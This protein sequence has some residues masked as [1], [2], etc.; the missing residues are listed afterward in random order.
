MSKCRKNKEPVHTNTKK[1]TVYSSKWRK[2]S[3]LA[4]GIKSNILKEKRQINVLKST[5]VFTSYIQLNYPFSD[6]VP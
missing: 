1:E 5:L 3:K 2:K 4:L 6:P